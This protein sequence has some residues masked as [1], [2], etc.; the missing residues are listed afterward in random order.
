M[1]LEFGI[2][3]PL[4]GAPEED[5]GEQEGV[6]FLHLLRRGGLEEGAFPDVLARGNHQREGLPFLGEI[7]GGRFIVI[8]LLSLLVN[9]GKPDLAKIARILHCQDLL[10]VL[11]QSPPLVHLVHDLFN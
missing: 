5:I 1:N 3:Q 2:R 11:H 6:S 4:L 10:L 7:G 9:Q 8:G